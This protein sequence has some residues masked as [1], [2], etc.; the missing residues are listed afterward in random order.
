MTTNQKTGLIGG[1]VVA[2]ILASVAIF[3][4]SKPKVVMFKGSWKGMAGLSKGDTLR[5][6]PGNYSYVPT[7][8]MNGIVV[9]YNGQTMTGNAAAARDT[10]CYFM[11]GKFLNVTGQYGAFQVDHLRGGGLF[12]CSFTNCSADVIGIGWNQSG[13]YDGVNPYTK[14]LSNF[15]VHD[16]TVTNSYGIMV[17]YKTGWINVIDSVRLH[18]FKVIGQKTVQ[19]VNLPD[20][21]RSR[22]DHWKVDQGNAGIPTAP[23][24]TLDQGMFEIAGSVSVD[25]CTEI[26][27]WGWFYRLVLITLNHEP[28]NVYGNVRI[29]AGNYNFMD[30]RAPDTYASSTYGGSL[31]LTNNTSGNAASKNNYV[32]PTVVIYK[33]TGDTITVARNIMFNCHQTRPTQDSAQIVNIG[34]KNASTGQQWP[35]G[36]IIQ[37]DNRYFNSSS[38]FAVDTITWMIKSSLPPVGAVTENTQTDTILPVTPCPPTY[39]HDTIIKHDTLYVPSSKKVVRIVNSDSSVQVIQ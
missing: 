13:K 5:L 37:Q 10:N 34:A 12:S 23:S 14:M 27:N 19:L 39:I 28:V 36:T 11:N 20:M 18:N 6:T 3:S 21:Y 2:L 32:T 15:D 33:S 25:S 24:G 22:I 1:G 4:S 26:G 17:N 35:T 29:N 16:I 31:Y 8:D 38:D 7:T 30:F 9:D